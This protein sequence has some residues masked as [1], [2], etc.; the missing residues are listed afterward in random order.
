MFVLCNAISITF[1]FKGWVVFLVFSLKTWPNLEH[2][3]LFAERRDKW[4]VTAQNIF[5]KK[6]KV[7]TTRDEAI[8]IICNI[9]HLYFIWF[10]RIGPSKAKACSDGQMSLIAY[11]CQKFRVRN[12]WVTPFN[13]S[14]PTPSSPY[15]AQTYTDWADC[16]VKKQTFL[17]LR[18]KKEVVDCLRFIRSLLCHSQITG[19]FL[20]TPPSHLLIPHSH[21]P[22]I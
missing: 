20:Q 21:R 15:F 17:N 5:F 19:N 10:S 13:S 8:S 16:S 18:L 12:S 1:P 2:L 3:E 6:K 7:Y 9:I 14:K 11:G 4:Q 22:P